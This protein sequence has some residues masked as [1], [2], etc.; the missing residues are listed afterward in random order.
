MLEATPDEFRLLLTCVTK[1]N[2][3]SRDSLLAQRTLEA[4]LGLG[5]EELVRRAGRGALE[6]FSHAVGTYTERHFTRIDR[7]LK[8]SY[9]VDRVLETSAPI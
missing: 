5:P 1:W 3:T 2:T 8:S 9:L 7:L 6:K 4:I